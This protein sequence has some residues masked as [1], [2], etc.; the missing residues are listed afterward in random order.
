VGWRQSLH[1]PGLF[2]C[3]LSGMAA[4]A[5]HQA[6][7]CSDGAI[8]ARES[9]I[10]RR[11][12]RR[13]DSVNAGRAHKP[14]IL[15]GR[16]VL[17]TGGSSGIGKAVANACVDAGA[18]VVICGR[19]VDALERA[20]CELETTASGGQRVIAIRA[21]VTDAAAVSELIASTVK[22]MPHLTGLVNAAG[23]LGSKGTLDEVDVDEWIATVQVNLIGTMLMCRA[24]LP[25]FRARCYGK[26]V[27]LSGGGATSPRPRFSAYAASKAAVVRLTEN[28]AQELAGAGIFLNAMA[29]GAVNTRMLEEVLEAGPAKVGEIAYKDA[30]KQK[31][32][33]GAPAKEAAALC[34]MLLA[35]ESDGITGR[36]VSAVWD[37]W[38]LLPD[39]KNELMKSDIYTLRRIVPA[40]RGLDWR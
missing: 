6:G 12:A 8:S 34:V 25:H 22:E 33:G 9:S 18:D 39:L 27:N 40:D 26:I 28:L 20:K 14:V 17:I 10:C 30:L 1:F 3:A 29:P 15:Q 16:A 36:L 31:E 13:S 21:D 7:G 35:G 23:I 24:V 37:P 19:G 5:Q 4:E 32:S 2:G 11:P 38:E